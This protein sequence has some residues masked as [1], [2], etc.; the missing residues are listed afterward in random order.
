MEDPNDQPHPPTRVKIRHL[1]S[2]LRAREQRSRII[3]RIIYAFLLYYLIVFIFF[4]SFTPFTVPKPVPSITRCRLLCQLQR[5]GE[6][7]SGPADDGGVGNE[8]R[9]FGNDGVEAYDYVPELAEMPAAVTTRPVA[10]SSTITLQELVDMDVE[11]L[12]AY[13]RAVRVALESSVDVA[14]QYE[15]GYRNV[16]Y[17]TM[18]LSLL[19]VRRYRDGTGTPGWDLDETRRWGIDGMHDEKAGEHSYT[20]RAAKRYHSL[21]KQKGSANRVTAATLGKALWDTLKTT[22]MYLVFLI[23]TLVIS[24]L[25]IAALVWLD[26]GENRAANRRK[27]MEAERL[28][29][30]KEEAEFWRTGGWTPLPPPPGPKGVTR[31]ICEYLW[32]RIYQPLSGYYTCLQGFVI[33]ILRILFWVSGHMCRLGALGSAGWLLYRFLLLLTKEDYER[34]N[35]VDWWLACIVQA[36]TAYSVVVLPVAVIFGIRILVEGG[37]DDRR[38]ETCELCAQPLWSEQLVQTDGKKL[39]HEHRR[40]DEERIVQEL[41]QREEEETQKKNSQKALT[42]PSG[43]PFR[44][45]PWAPIPQRPSTLDLSHVYARDTERFLGSWQRFPQSHSKR[46]PDVGWGSIYHRHPDGGW[47]HSF[48]DT[49]TPKPRRDRFS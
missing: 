44:P 15:D 2:K 33:G 4:P 3:W 49:C 27:K 13:Q 45:V 39:C 19:E 7:V 18:E 46:Q 26:G 38:V 40:Q 34:D 9:R 42:L 48:K 21:T 8:G 41:K 22:V 6:W 20:P 29:K 36:T 11:A 35:R 32:S 28:A 47:K 23:S 1:Q 16:E 17:D 25:L 31:R 43:Q 10:P 5:F 37:Q 12:L 14:G 24:A 30:E